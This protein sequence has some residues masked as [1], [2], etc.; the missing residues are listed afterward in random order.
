MIP[1]FMAPLDLCGVFQLST[2]YIHKPYFL[3]LWLLSASSLCYFFSFA[4]LISFF[5]LLC[6]PPQY[7]QWG[8]YGKLCFIIVSILNYVLH[9]TAM[10]KWRIE[11]FLKGVDGS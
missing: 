7:R 10:A 2:E 5:P 8:W 6:F 4:F 11:T 1:G 3:G 9:Q